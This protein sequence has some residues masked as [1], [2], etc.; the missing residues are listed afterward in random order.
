MNAQAQTLLFRVRT[1]TSIQ[2][3]TSGGTLTVQAPR[4]GGSVDFEVIASYQGP[5]QATIVRSELV[6][7]ADFRLTQI[8]SSTPGALQPA[9]SFRWSGHYTA[10]SGARAEAQLAVTLRESAPDGVILGQAVHILNIAGTAPDVF[11]YA[12][13]ETERFQPLTNGAT[14]RL[15]SVVAGSTSASVPVVISNRGT[16][17]TSV[18]AVALQSPHFQFTQLAALPT[19]VEPSGE[20]RFGIRYAPRDAGTHSSRMTLRI[21]GSDLA[22]ELEGSTTAAPASA[23]RYFRIEGLNRAPMTPGTVV[24]LPS[25]PAAGRST[26]IVRIENSGTADITLPIS[27]DGGPFSIAEAPGLTSISAGSS[28]DLTIL[29]QPQRIGAVEGLLRVGPDF[30]PLHA[31]GLGPELKFSYQ[32]DSGTVP[33]THGGNVFLGSTPVGTPLRRRFTIENTGTE[34]AEIPVVQ[35]SG[36]HAEFRLQD[37]PPTPLSLAPGDSASLQIV[38]AP[39]TPGQF[40]DALLVGSNVI[41]VS[42]AGAA[43]PSLPPYEITTSLVSAEPARQASAGL[44]LREPYPL[45]LT[46]AL[47]L[48]VSPHN[49][50][51]DPAVQF[52][53]GGR[54]VPFRIAA[55]TT[56]AMFE[57]GTPSVAF[58]TGTLAGTLIFTAAFTGPGNIEM[59]SS[60]PATLSI[61]V[62]TVAPVLLS[63]RAADVS[64]NNVSFVVNG[65]DTDRSLRR[66]F[67]RLWLE[68]GTETE[69]VYDVSAQARLWFGTAL[70]DGFGGLF[71]FT[72]PFVRS[73]PAVRIQSA[74]FVA[75]SGAGRS[76][77]VTANV[78]SEVIR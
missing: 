57:D 15:P 7:P 3:A 36:T 66:F 39:A 21:G 62:P 35:L 68:S 51:V 60:A 37:V 38:F 64:S 63:A 59:T 22:V 75:E 47:T 26:A 74:V 32:T 55:G 54:V 33:T 56:D 24:T 48:R 10:A 71:S 58:Q 1:A 13:T 44:R 16:A 18:E 9:D 43:P 20:F 12:I 29:F 69:L 53:S 46:G 19:I 76:N 61:T 41:A 73:G 77:A 2:A 50:A 11:V 65:Y 49:T 6:G 70:S 34:A 42:A 31:V 23:I 27:T 45:P 67:V 25:S 14:F 17:P 28:L 78:P 4:V 8:A 52:G 40:S 5:N 72:L 30:F